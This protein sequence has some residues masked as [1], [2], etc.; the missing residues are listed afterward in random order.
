LV[1]LS[2]NLSLRDRL[3][4]ARA[5]LKS[6]DVLRTELESLRHQQHAHMIRVA[7]VELLRKQAAEVHRLRGQAAEALRLQ[8][9]IDLLRSQLEENEQL[10]MSLEVQ[11]SQRSLPPAGEPPSE[12]ANF[13]QLTP[14]DSPSDDKAQALRDD[15]PVY[16]AQF[17]PDGRYILTATPDGTARIWDVATAQP[18][19]PDFDSEP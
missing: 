8:S 14:S 7:E 18:L 6:A 13:G 5:Q 1:S 17:S 19:T 9:E 10:V 3:T 16:Y 2:R 11:L 4:E 12:T 15:G